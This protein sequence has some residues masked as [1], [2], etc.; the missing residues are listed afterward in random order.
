MMVMTLFCGFFEADRPYKSLR[1]YE[2]VKLIEH[3]LFTAVNSYSVKNVP[4]QM[5]GMLGW[6]EKYLWYCLLH[7]NIARNKQMMKF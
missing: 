5:F 4:C 2:N 6:F 3:T 1:N 7:K